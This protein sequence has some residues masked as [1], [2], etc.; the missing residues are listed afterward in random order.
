[1]QP[2][3]DAHWLW[4]VGIDAKT[5]GMGSA[6]L[7]LGST[8]F[9]DGS[10]ERGK[11]PGPSA[12]L[13]VTYSGGGI[14]PTTN[15]PASFVWGLVDFEGCPL[16]IVLPSVHI[17]PCVAFNSGFVRGSESSDNTTP[18]TAVHP[19]FSAGVLGRVEWLT[20]DVFQLEL[21]LGAIVPFTRD[22]FYFGPATPIYEVPSVVGT[23]A[24]G[25][26]VRIP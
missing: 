19:W 17:R 8:V 18:L 11:R 7:E 20:S 4:T 14:V 1:V 2:A 10:H 16:P 3:A 9:V 26:G 15:G 21:A 12:R 13:G 25:F 6:G 5:M 23:A 24:L 22:P